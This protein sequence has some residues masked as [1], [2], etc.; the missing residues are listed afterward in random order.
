MHKISNFVCLRWLL[1]VK[2]YGGCGMLYSSA[3][4]EQNYWCYSA[5]FIDKVIHEPLNC[6]WFHRG[7]FSTSSL[8]R[9]VLLCPVLCL[10][11]DQNTCPWNVGDSHILEMEIK[12]WDAQLYKTFVMNWGQWKERCLSGID[13]QFVTEGANGCVF[14][15]LFGDW[16]LW[17]HLSGHASFSSWSLE[18]V[19]LIC[20]SKILP[21][22]RADYHIFNCT[23]CHSQW[24][25]W[26]WL[27]YSQ[28]G[29]DTTFVL[30]RYTI[31]WR[32]SMEPH[33]YIS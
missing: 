11:E 10:L 4:F 25:G 29:K 3:P 23:H 19:S 24:R 6:I 8:E 17:L 16:W 21:E 5:S 22:V 9:S 32:F 7:M 2:F 33:S 20:F 1:D 13:L 28:A 18:Y 27:W 15:V 31:W 12:V 26:C 30:L 14:N